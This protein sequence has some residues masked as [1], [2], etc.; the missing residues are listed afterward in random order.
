M[1]K[2]NISIALRDVMA[3]SPSAVIL[4]KKT[5]KFTKLNSFYF[6]EYYEIIKLNVYIYSTF[7]PNIT[8]LTC[9]YV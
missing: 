4:E 9:M 7:V 8:L 5:A 1:T 2:F 3:N 6:H